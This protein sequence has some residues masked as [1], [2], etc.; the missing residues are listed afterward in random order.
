MT[1]KP[2]RKAGVPRFLAVLFVLGIIAGCLGAGLKIYY[3]R[4]LDAMTEEGIIRN[5][6]L[7]DHAVRQA[8]SEQ[9]IRDYVKE[10]ATMIIR[11]DEADMRAIVRKSLELVIQNSPDDFRI[12]YTWDE[13][14]YKERLDKVTEKV[15]TDGEFTSDLKDLTAKFRNRLGFRWYLLKV[16]LYS[17]EIMIAGFVLAAAALILWFVFGGVSAGMVRGGLVPA[18]LIAAAC[19][20][21]ILL[22]A[23]KA[24]PAYSREFDIGSFIARHF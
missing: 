16:V 21:A 4:T 1:E 14:I 2:V 24:P 3:D 6:A 9:E 17:R 15:L 5:G 13:A 12:Y 11:Q 20:G 19:A 8:L 10:F 23:L 7:A 22:L 18:L